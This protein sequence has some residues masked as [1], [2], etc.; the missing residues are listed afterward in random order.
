MAV[1]ALNGT[2]DLQGSENLLPYVQAIGNNFD[3]VKSV[4]GPSNKYIQTISIDGEHVTIESTTNIHSTAF[5]GKLNAENE[6]VT[7]DNRK[8]K[9]I[10][11]VDGG[12]LLHV[13]KW[14]DAVNSIVREVR[15]GKL[16]ATY[17]IG[18]VVMKR[19]FQKIR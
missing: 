15:D 7:L 2:W 12:K 14:G 6:E 5:T 10:V 3:A 11:S 16:Y 8:V 4:L 19:S 17:T 13:Q 1:K 9:S 18:N